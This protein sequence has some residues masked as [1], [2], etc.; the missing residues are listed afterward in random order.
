MGGDKAHLIM[1]RGMVGL[2]SL[3]ARKKLFGA[4]LNR[5]WS[6]LDPDGGILLFETPRR[7]VLLEKGIVLKD[8]VN[9]LQK[10]VDTRYFPGIIRDYDPVTEGGKIMI[11]RTLN[12][13]SSLPSI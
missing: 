13:P 6:L 11:T 4:L 3:P 12:S 9:S 5:A 8:W 2:S 1:E 10:V 7:D